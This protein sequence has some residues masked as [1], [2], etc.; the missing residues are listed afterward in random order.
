MKKLRAFTLAETIMTLFIVGLVVTAS[1]PMFTKSRSSAPES[2]SPWNYCNTTRDTGLCVAPKQEGGTEYP[3]VVIGGGEVDTNYGLTV[4]SSGVA[5]YFSPFDMFKSDN[6]KFR[7]GD[8]YFAEDKSNLYIDNQAVFNNAN[9]ANVLIGYN[10]IGTGELS[11]SVIIGKNN[12]ANN[13][14]VS[15]SVLIGNNSNSNNN[16]IT[17]SVIIGENSDGTNAVKIGKVSGTNSGLYIG[18]NIITA[19]DNGIN[20][21]GVITGDNNSINFTQD[22]TVNDSL[23]VQG[24]LTTTALNTSS[25]ERLKNIKEEY[26]KGLNEV[27]QIEP[28]V[29]KYKGQNK[30][31]IG[32]IAQDVQ[33]IFPE[34]VV[35][36]PDG[37]LGVNTD[38]IF[39]GMLN[40]LKEINS[41]TDKELKRQAKL[42]EELE[43]IQNDIEKLSACSAND[44]KSKIKCFFFDAKMFFKS[45]LSCHYSDFDRNDSSYNHRSK[46]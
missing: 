36:M 24:A 9:I 46:V 37:F 11:N 16:H 12:I 28:V 2:T 39:F 5:A 44:F 42:Q 23:T 38:P 4:N 3:Q 45:L 41:K 26:T 7:V 21:G 25:D 15:N 17:D 32:V 6:R 40:A 34:A 8:Y 27:L 20:I 18:H 19:N 22:V 30:K 33:K 43:E 13:V 14:N 31:N 29:F 10:T 35:K 1:I